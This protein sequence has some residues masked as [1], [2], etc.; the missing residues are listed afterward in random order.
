MK[1]SILT[2]VLIVLSLGLASDWVKAE[3]EHSVKPENGFVPDRH[4]AIKIA[5]AVLI[6]IYGQKVIKKERPFTASLTNDVWVVEGS[7]PKRLLFTAS[8]GVAIVELSKKDGRILR[9]T[10]GK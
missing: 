2:Y 4:T 9:V 3:P 6:P 10:H 5:E 7:L 1:R 8:G